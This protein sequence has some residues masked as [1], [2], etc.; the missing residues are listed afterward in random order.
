MEI[1]YN[2]EVEIFADFIERIRGIVANPLNCPNGNQYEN[3][4]ILPK[5]VNDDQ[6]YL[7]LRLFKSIPIFRGVYIL[8]RRIDLYILAFHPDVQGQV[9][10]ILRDDD[11]VNRKI[12]SSFLKV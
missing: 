2:I 4:L 12:V 8:I 11:D 6:E 10:L 3:L 9:W 1:T 7:A 5:N